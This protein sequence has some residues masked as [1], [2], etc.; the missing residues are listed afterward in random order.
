MSESATTKKKVKRQK[1]PIVDEEVKQP[2][3]IVEPVK[4]EIV[5]PRPLL[6][7]KSD[8]A[9]TEHRLP[10]NELVAMF[11]SSNINA[12]D[13]WSSKGLS[14]DDAVALLAKNGPNELTPPKEM[15]EL[16]RFARQF[17]NLLMILLMIAGFLSLAAFIY[18]TADLTNLYLA[19]ILLVAVVLTCTISY[20]EER[21]TAKVMR[22]FQAMLP[23]DAAVMRNGEVHTMPTSQLVVGDL[24]KVTAGMKVSQII[25]CWLLLDCAFINKKNLGSC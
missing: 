11:T 22:T 1:E 6:A 16:E 10:M 21:G 9:I 18:N 2:A 24:V 14:T 23:P 3:K 4:E 8:G 17:L 25:F 5:E 15:G 20:I 12:N 19:I 13:A 7:F